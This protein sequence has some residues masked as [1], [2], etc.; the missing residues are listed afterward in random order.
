M[1]GVCVRVCV[2]VLGRNCG[3]WS[4][5]AIFTYKQSTLRQL[6]MLLYYCFMKTIEN[7]YT[8]TKDGLAFKTSEWI[9]E[10]GFSCIFTYINATILDMYVCLRSVV[11][12]KCSSSQLYG[13]FR[14]QRAEEWNRRDSDAGV[15]SKVWL[16]AFNPQ[17]GFSAVP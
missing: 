1:L 3:L 8:D 15:Y 17:L 5:F 11:I 10:L 13:R 2:S 6:Y 9:F 14:E 4:V 16:C 7:I 12:K